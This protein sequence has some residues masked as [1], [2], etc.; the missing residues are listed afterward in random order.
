MQV[1]DHD[2]GKQVIL[3]MT[4]EYVADISRLNTP[5]PH[6]RKQLRQRRTKS[7][8]IQLIDQCLDCGKSI[9][10]FHKHSLRLA[11][12]PAWDDK[13]LISYRAAREQKYAD[14][15]QKHVRIQ[16][17]RTVQIYGKCSTNIS[18]QMNRQKKRTKVLERANEVCEG[19]GLKRATQVH[20][21]TYM[22]RFNE[23]LFELVAVC[24]QCHER[25]HAT[26]VNVSIKSNSKYA[27][28]RSMKT[29]LR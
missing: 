3:E 1:V 27:S 9:G 7:D 18:N 22:H 23:F 2:T 16:R 6:V 19:C 11:E 5:C 24:D 10:Q 29:L 4:P 17:D 12:V 13:L 21:L 25:L 28:Y 8:T 20:H 14:I 15:K 26:D